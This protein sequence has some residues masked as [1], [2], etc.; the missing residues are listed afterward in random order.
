VFRIF[1]RG[2]RSLSTRLGEAFPAAVWLDNIKR[3][4]LFAH[5][6]AI[7]KDRYERYLSGTSKVNQGSLVIYDRFPLEQFSSGSEFRLLDGPQSQNSGERTQGAVSKILIKKELGYY[8]KMFLPDFIFV[9]DVD[10]EVSIQRKPD[11]DA[12]V[13]AVKN[14]VIR[15]LIEYSDDGNHLEQIIQINANR[16][17]EEVF[18]HLKSA[19]WEIL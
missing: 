11:H 3:N 7:G 15:N 12:A 16:P 19:V 1:R 18:K 8:D 9:L 17:F 14:R 10:P 6:V 5:Y 13:L 2:H 4:I